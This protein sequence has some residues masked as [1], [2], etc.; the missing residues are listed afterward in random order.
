MRTRGWMVAAFLAMHGIAM[1]QG[2]GAGRQ[3]ID[4]WASVYGPNTAYTLSN[5][6]E[7]VAGRELAIGIDRGAWLVD[8]N[9]IVP[10]NVTLFVKRGSYFLLTNSATMAIRGEIAAGD[11][12]VFMKAPEGGECMVDGTNGTFT[13]ATS[14]WF[15]GGIDW[16]G[17]ARLLDLEALAGLYLWTSNSLALLDQNFSN[18]NDDFQIVNQNF[19][20]VSGDFHSVAGTVNDHA[21]LIR[22]NAVAHNLNWWYVLPNLFD[23]LFDGVDGWD[24]AAFTNSLWAANTNAGTI[25]PSG[26]GNYFSLTNWY[27]NRFS[28]VVMPWTHGVVDPVS[29]AVAS[30]MFDG[31]YVSHWG[32]ASNG[33]RTV[34]TNVYPASAG[35][36]DYAFIFRTNTPGSYAAYSGPFGWKKS[37]GAIEGV[38]ISAHGRY[39][40]FVQL[41]VADVTPAYSAT[42]S[43]AEGSFLFTLRFF[44]TSDA[45]MER[46]AGIGRMVR[47]SDQAWV[48]DMDV[49][50][51]G[52]PAAYETQL[53]Y[54][55]TF[56][57]ADD[58]LAAAGGAI[59]VKAM[60]GYIPD[61]A[62]VDSRHMVRAAK[63][64]ILRTASW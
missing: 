21:G 25:S 52:P 35:Y 44:D 63:M 62:T 17:R 19:S 48:P 34:Y 2:I 59:T 22:S 3:P 24:R 46:W 43:A 12:L 7:Q 20:S 33:T 27:F 16:A 4:V 6:F 55:D 50:G 13:F 26:L 38:S 60:A 8:E 57:V 39:S 28:D 42:N 11:H 41:R 1:G 31:A 32:Y 49:A 18:L 47:P 29:N 45:P 61:G 53:F 36:A 9:L 56:L 5:V 40:V 23:Q 30:L 54:A 14:N 51:F 37:G 10:S 15:G 58:E 64:T